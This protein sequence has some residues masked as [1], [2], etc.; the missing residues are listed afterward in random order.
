MC[1][2]LGLQPETKISSY[3]YGRM[4]EMS[5]QLKFCGST[6]GKGRKEI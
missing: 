3:C 2:E 5:Q 4:R 1:Q 6:T